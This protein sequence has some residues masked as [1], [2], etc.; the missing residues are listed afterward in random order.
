[1]STTLLEQFMT[2]E[3]TPFV[4]ELLR[5]AVQQRSSGGIPEVRRFEFNRF[6]V[7]IDLGER[8][9][10]I[11]DVLDSTELGSCRTSMDEFTAALNR[12]PVE[13]R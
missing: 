13:A 4:C 1:M 11:Q 5:G 12:L 7:I 9:V 2:E 6:E 8:T 10:L 3:C